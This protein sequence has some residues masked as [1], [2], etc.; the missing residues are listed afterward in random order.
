[1][2]RAKPAEPIDMPFGLWTP[3]GPRNNV[4]LFDEVQIPTCEGTILRGKMDGSVHIPTCQAVDILRHIPGSTGTV[5]M[6]IGA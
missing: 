2:S 1:V 4:G 5:R 3:V 6:P